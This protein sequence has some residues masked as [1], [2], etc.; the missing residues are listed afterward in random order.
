MAKFFDC[1]IRNNI[2]YKSFLNKS[3]E[4]YIKLGRQK[5]GRDDKDPRRSIDIQ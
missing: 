2:R 1:M 5:G 4:Y 3:E